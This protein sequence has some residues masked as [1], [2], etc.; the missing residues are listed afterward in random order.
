M[1]NSLSKGY[2]SDLKKAA[3]K[4]GFKISESFKFDDFY[5]VDLILDLEISF[6]VSTFLKCRQNKHFG[7]EFRR[8]RFNIESSQTKAESGRVERCQRQMVDRFEQ[9]GQIVRRG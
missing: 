2:L 1:P 7:H 9:V 5:L 3:T 4:N 6:F 8:Q